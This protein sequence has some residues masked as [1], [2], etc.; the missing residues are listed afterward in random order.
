MNCRVE[1]GTDSVMIMY[2]VV[3]VKGELQSAVWDRQYYDHVLC[4]VG[5]G[6]LQS[7]VWD[8][9]YYDHVMCCVGEG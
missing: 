1:C 8:R 3:K 5:E 9:Q 6:L 2:C 4:C 7:G